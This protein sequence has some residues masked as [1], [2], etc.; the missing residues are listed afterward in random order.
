M[1]DVAGQ[2]KKRRKTQGLKNI[3]GIDSTGDPEGESNDAK[4]NQTDRLG[5]K[6]NP[7]DQKGM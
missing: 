7:D 4:V 5:E 3:P 6:T 2:W 1:S